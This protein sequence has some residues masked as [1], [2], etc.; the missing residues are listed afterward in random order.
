MICRRPVAELALGADAGFAAIAPSSASTA[1]GVR[2]PE[3][4]HLD[5][6]LPVQEQILGLDVT[7]H[8]A[9]VVSTFEPAGRWKDISHGLFD[10]EPLLLADQFG[11]RL[12]LDILPAEIRPA[13]VLAKIED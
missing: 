1:S 2:R 3:V 5:H 13:L 8:H 6:P 4:G 11:K 9:L 12:P 7:V 10:V